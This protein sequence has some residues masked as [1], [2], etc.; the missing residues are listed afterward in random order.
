MSQRNNRFVTPD[1]MVQPNSLSSTGLHRSFVAL[2]DAVVE[3]AH[4]GVNIVTEYPG[5]YRAMLDNQ[6]LFGL[7]LKRIKTNTKKV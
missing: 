3:D 7:F 1:I 2:L 6:S 5:F 4:D